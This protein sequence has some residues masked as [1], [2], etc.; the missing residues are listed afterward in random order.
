MNPCPEELQELEFIEF[1][2]EF[3][4]SE[5]QGFVLH[6][7]GVVFVDEHTHVQNVTFAT[8]FINLFSRFGRQY[9]AKAAALNALGKIVS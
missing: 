3:C 7:N 6:E 8:D 9:T 2:R 1:K 4:V 5:N